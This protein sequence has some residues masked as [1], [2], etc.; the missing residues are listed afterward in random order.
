MRHPLH[1]DR[2][3]RTEMLRN[4]AQPKP[5]RVMDLGR[6]AGT[7]LPGPSEIPCLGNAAKD[8]GPPKAT[9]VS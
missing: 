6:H 2:S 4:K 7:V 9:R 5:E 3:Y 1:F 8:A